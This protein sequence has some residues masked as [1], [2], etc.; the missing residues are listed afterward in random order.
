[1]RN[2]PHEG[3]RRHVR[4]E[5]TPKMIL[6]PIIIFARHLESC[7]RQWRESSLC[8]LPRLVNS[9]QVFVRHLFELSCSCLFDLVLFLSCTMPVFNSGPAFFQAAL[10]A[11]FRGV[12]GFLGVSGASECR[13]CF[14]RACF[15]TRSFVASPRFRGGG[16]SNVALCI[17][18]SALSSARITS[19]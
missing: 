6:A 8:C 1:M 17:G 3:S 7:Q 16:S 10:A 2:V 19:S 5:R 13:R 18:A 12:V 14:E 4:A 15:P 9:Y 11:A